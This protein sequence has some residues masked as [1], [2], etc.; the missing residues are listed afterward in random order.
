MGQGARQIR[1]R[2]TERLLSDC[3]APSFST[4]VSS[5]AFGI[6]A[7]SYRIISSSGSVLLRW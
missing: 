2:L 4:D 6:F 1:E 3:S 7:R 5:D